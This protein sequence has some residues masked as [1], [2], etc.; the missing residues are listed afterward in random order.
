[1]SGKEAYIWL[2]TRG[3]GV[4][5]SPARH[6]SPMFIRVFSLLR[7]SRGNRV[8][9]DVQQICQILPQPSVVGQFPVNAFGRSRPAADATRE[10]GEHWLLDGLM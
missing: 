6:F 8:Q 2:R 9:D 5:I 1:M 7:V 4:R 10:A 3:S